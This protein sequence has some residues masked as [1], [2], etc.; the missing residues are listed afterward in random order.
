MWPYLEHDNVF[1]ILA[2]RWL[3]CALGEPVRQMKIIFLRHP[4]D[5]VDLF[6]RAESS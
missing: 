2:S 1:S 5:R 6:F 4:T 3:E